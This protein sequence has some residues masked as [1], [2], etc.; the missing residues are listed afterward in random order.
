MN[1]NIR[2]SVFTP[3]A[4]PEATTGQTGRTVAAKIRAAEAIYGARAARA[5][6]ARERGSA[7]EK[8]GEKARSQ[9]HAQPHAHAH[10]Q[11]QPQ[12]EI[13]TARA[14]RVAHTP[15]PAAAEV[16]VAVVDTASPAVPGDGVDHLFGPLPSFVP[17]AVQ[18]V[19][20]EAVRGVAGGAVSPEYVGGQQDA[21]TYSV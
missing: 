19:V 10:V 14:A 9:A 3:A 13:G 12:A 15:H 5:A 16:T 6:K 17:E 21:G 8:A 11:P 18:E 7:G 1:K 20:Q 2:R 4:G